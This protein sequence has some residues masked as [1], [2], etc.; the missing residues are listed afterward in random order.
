VREQFAAH[1]ASVGQTQEA[2]LAAAATVARAGGSGG[3]GPGAAAAAAAG[4][5]LLDLGSGGDLAAAVAL[6]ALAAA[7][8]QMQR[9]VSE[10][11]ARPRQPNAVDPSVAL[12]PGL[13]RHRQAVTATDSTL[14]RIAGA[15]S[16]PDGAKKLA[17]TTVPASNHRPVWQQLM[18]NKY[19][20]GDGGEKAIAGG[21]ESSPP[22]GERGGAGTSSSFVRH[23]GER[24]V[25]LK[26]TAAQQAER[27]H[28]RRQ[29]RTPPIAYILCKWGV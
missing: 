20:G 11:L 5:A 25:W 4:T 13:P 24:S 27:Q 9:A 17:A 10:R 6:P 22:G 18:D 3:G 14:P 8:T 19:G 12:Q 7:L 1:G 21:A 16:S 28:Q 23:I 29:F 15:S 26:A 2:I